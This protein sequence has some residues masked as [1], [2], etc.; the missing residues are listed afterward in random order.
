MINLISKPVRW[1]GFGKRTLIAA[2]T[3]AITAFLC[4]SPGIAYAA[5]LHVQT[6]DVTYD[7][8]PQRSA[9]S[10]TCDSTALVHGADYVTSWRKNV[11]AGMATVKVTGR[12]SYSGLTGTATFKISAAP[13][14]QTTVSGIES[15]YTYTGKP[16]CPSPHVELHGKSLVE[17]LDYETKYIRN[18][19]AGTAQLVIHG[20]RNLQGDLTR[21]YSI[22]APAKKPA[23]VKASLATATVSVKSTSY[24]G[25]ALTPKP[26]VKLGGKTL[27]AGT[28]YTVSYSQNKNVGTA[29]LTIKGKG[30]YTGSK[31]A[32]FKIAKA[33]IA[34]ARIEKIGARYTTSLSKVTPALTVTFKGTKLKKDRDYTVK[35]S[36]NK[37]PGTATA[38]IRGTGKFKGTK[39][40]TFKLVNM[41]DDLARA[42]CKLSYSRGKFYDYG[43]YP[44]TKKYLS[45]FYLAGKR[46]KY[47][48]G[49]SCDVGMSTIMKWSGYDKGF[50]GGSS[51]QKP[52]LG[53]QKDKAKT[54]RWVCVGA[55]KKGDIE[56][57]GLMPGDILQ[58][59]RHIW[60][61]VGGQ[62]PQ[63]IYA[64]YLKGTDADLGKPT[65]V[66]VSSHHGH[67]NRNTKSAALGIGG[68]SYSYTDSYGNSVRI[69]RCVKP[70]DTQYRAGKAVS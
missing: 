6:V 18:T 50:P 9:L 5:G 25:K 1:D 30:A 17:G 49:R 48:A 57:S 3:L 4:A 40:T 7:G 32:S 58:S 14:Q 52:Y 26:T 46:Y 68:T 36:N 56:G 44:G 67:A 69:Y 23:T 10:V 45:L 20:K 70:S 43:K 59:E 22:I 34:K 24:T 21:S 27:K 12:G 63:D 53:Y 42:A 8:A 2:F 65:G 51:L 11:N 60:M 33:D 39:S 29:Q 19:E 61:Y 54:T 31:T 15:S 37:K 13:I 47:T 38:T 16:I 35:Y 28:D 62:I 64:K 66:W 41:G 55:Y